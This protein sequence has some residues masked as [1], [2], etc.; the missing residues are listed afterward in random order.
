M[1]RKQISVC[2]RR[3]TLGPQLTR[4]VS[5]SKIVGGLPRAGLFAFSR[6]RQ[7]E[8]IKRIFFAASSSSTV[9]DSPARMKPW[10]YA[11]KWAVGAKVVDKR[12]SSSQ[13]RMT[14]ALGRDEV[15]CQFVTME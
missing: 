5:I 2:R 6:S 10:T 14:E 4:P 15:G 8:A 12:H 11:S 1:R 13:P 3:T 7:Y 9:N